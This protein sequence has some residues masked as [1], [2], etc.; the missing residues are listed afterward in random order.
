MYAERLITAEEFERMP[1]E[2][3]V[4]ME[5]VRGRVVRMSPP[6]Y[7]HG[8]VASR[9]FE[10]LVSHVTAANLGHL[11]LPV[12]FK[13]ESNPD[14]VREPDFA[15]VSRARLASVPDGFYQGPPDL[16]VEVVSP[17]QSRA[18]VARKAAQYVERGVRLVWVLDAK[19][20]TVTVYRQGEQP[21]I[22]RG[23]AQLQGGDV[24]P[25]FSCEAARIFA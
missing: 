3:G 21:R 12:G 10:L 5:L 9:L 7:R 11:V 18:A 1:E 22:L 2:D 23:K 20:E 8:L 6:G 14:T 17:R 19:L 4:R 16:A 15:F 13:I 25:G 24:I